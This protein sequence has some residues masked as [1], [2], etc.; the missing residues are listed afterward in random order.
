MSV[1]RRVEEHPAA[2]VIV[3]V[4]CGYEA[5]AITTGLVPTI[6]SLDRRHPWIGP[7]VLVGLAWHFHHPGED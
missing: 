6:T 5:V 4:A 1:L 7:A 3:A 2:R